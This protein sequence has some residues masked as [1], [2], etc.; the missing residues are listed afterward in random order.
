MRSI[1]KNVN[2][3]VSFLL[4]SCLESAFLSRSAYRSLVGLPKIRILDIAVDKQSVPVIAHRCKESVLDRD[5]DRVLL[6]RESRASQVGEIPAGS[7]TKRS[8]AT[9]RLATMR[10]RAFTLRCA[11]VMPATLISSSSTQLNTMDLYELVIRWRD[12]RAR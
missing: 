9:A 1:S 12:T 7:A 4:R 10:F 6:Q 2:E 11:K 5:R 3:T 8:A